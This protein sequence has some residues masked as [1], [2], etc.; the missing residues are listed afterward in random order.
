MTL[1][2]EIFSRTRENISPHDPWKL[3]ES[4]ALY[5]RT[6]A[7]TLLPFTP[8]TMKPGQL[9]A[10]EYIK[11]ENRAGRSV[12]VRWL[13]YRQGGFSTLAEAIMFSQTLCRD[14]QNALV[15]SNVEDT[16]QWI[17]GMSQLMQAEME[18]RGTSWL[19]THY[20]NRREISWK[21]SKSSIRIGSAQS[22]NIGITETRG[23][24]HLSEVAYYPNWAFLWGNLS[25]SIPTHLPGCI[26]IM[27][28]TAN[29][30]GDHFHQGW[31][32]GQ[33][34]EGGF[35]NMFFAWFEDPDYAVKV[36]PGVELTE[37][38]CTIRDT[39]ELTIEQMYWRR[40]KIADDFAGDESL[41]KEKFPASPEEAFRSTGS[42]V[43]DSIKNTLHQV[44]VKAPSG[45]LGGVDKIENGLVW[46]PHPGGIVERFQEPQRGHK[47]ICYSDVGE[48]LKNVDSDP[49]FLDGKRITTS[50]STCI[51]RKV[52]DWSL[53][54]I[55]E[56][57]YPTDV[58][59]Q[60]AG[61]LAEY[62]NHALWGIEIPG[63]GQAVIA[64]AQEHY[65]NLYKR[66]WRDALNDFQRM[67][68]YG[69]RNDARTKPMMEATWM[70]FVRDYGDKL[71]SRRIAAQA[72]TY[73]QDER[74][75]KHRPKSGCFSDLLL[76]DFGCLQLLKSSPAVD[77]R[78]IAQKA[79]AYQ[80]QSEPKRKSY[81]R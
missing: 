8:E 52:Q 15:L 60:V 65:D 71:G 37:E 55:M 23:L 5:I 56:C 62:Y 10:Y 7:G 47:Y 64:W 74:S 61:N 45:E 39:H 20:S 81:F 19:E 70:S 51:V 6:K 11:A 41:F 69:F 25:P 27:E 50:Y 73:I 33:R 42:I 13:K 67:R 78:A 77:E 32:A 16:A 79:R 1:T 75:G 53:C 30:A 72:I 63:P 38:E 35:H 26:V 17:Y 22:K 48:G 36:P 3:I 49:I 28:S 59:S 46:T 76:A 66:E 29:G 43:F 58:F 4:G 80:R 40:R 24:V 44:M 68:E 57:R 12:Q 14:Y 2:T 54:A 9:R 21:G 34:G 31:L 18:S